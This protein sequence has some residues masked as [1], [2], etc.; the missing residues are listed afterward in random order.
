MITRTAHSV[1]PLFRRQKQFLIYFP[2]VGLCNLLT[3]S[4]S[5][6]SLLIMPEPIFTKLG[7]YIMT[8]TPN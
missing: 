8:P 1:T 3:V 6:Y 4:A 2:K 7:M 5:V